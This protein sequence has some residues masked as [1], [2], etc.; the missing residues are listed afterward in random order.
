MTAAKKDIKEVKKNLKTC[1]KKS[2]ESSKG[3]RNIADFVYNTN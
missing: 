2:K 1:L 3:F